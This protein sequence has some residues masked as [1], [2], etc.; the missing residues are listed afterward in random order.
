[1]VTTSFSAYH[2]VSSWLR[3]VQTGAPGF[4]DEGEGLMLRERPSAQAA[5]MVSIQP[6]RGSVSTIWPDAEIACDHAQAVIPVLAS[7]YSSMILL[8]RNGPFAV[9]L[10]VS[11]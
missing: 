2:T 9:I 11:C 4:L 10:H 8:I 1:M 6:S 5:P 3:M 7:F